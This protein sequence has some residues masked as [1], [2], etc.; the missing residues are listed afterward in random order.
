M[1]RSRILVVASVITIAA[2]SITVLTDRAEL[3]ESI[4]TSSENSSVNHEEKNYVLEST[5]MDSL[6]GIYLSIGQDCPISIRISGDSILFYN[7]IYFISGSLFVVNKIA[8]SGLIIRAKSPSKT[9]IA[10]SIEMAFDGFRF[11]TI[12]NYG[13]A[14]A[15]WEIWPNCTPK[16][17][18]FEKDE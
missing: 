1:N 18:R 14:D 10:D 5:Y 9:Y 16:Y 7:G 11:T 2:C 12:Q 3:N 4:R 8:G 15:D 17:I 6:A 13:N